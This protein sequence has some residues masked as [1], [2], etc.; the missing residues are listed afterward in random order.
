MTK[1]ENEPR[2]WIRVLIDMRM[3][4]ERGDKAGAAEIMRKYGEM[5][6]TGAAS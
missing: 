3:A 6:E 1:I 2:G 4:L 5:R